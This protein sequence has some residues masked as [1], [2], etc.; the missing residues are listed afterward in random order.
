M[1]I[2]SIFNR[3]MFMKLVLF[4]NSKKFIYNDY[5]SLCKDWDHI[6]SSCGYNGTGGDWRHYS[7]V[8]HSLHQTLENDKPL[9]VWKSWWEVFNPTI[10][11]VY[12]TEQLANNF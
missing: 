10:S 2:L 7:L 9:N 11:L 1:T 5:P 4:L 12:T 3:Y 8:I 6:T